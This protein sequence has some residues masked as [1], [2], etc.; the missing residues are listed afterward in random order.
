VYLTD[1]S[2]SEAAT[3]TAGQFSYALT[4]TPF[5]GFNGHFA[6]YV[7]VD[8]GSLPLARRYSDAYGPNFPGK[9]LYVVNSEVDVPVSIVSSGPVPFA[10]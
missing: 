2:N 10:R 8:V 4:S 5:G 6:N 3:V 9:G 1:I 7:A